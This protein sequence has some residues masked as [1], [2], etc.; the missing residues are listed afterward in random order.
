MHA[1][2]SVIALLGV[3]LTSFGVS[4]G[5]PMAA[6]IV[7]LLMIWEGREATIPLVRLGIENPYGRIKP[8][9][10]NDRSRFMGRSGTSTRERALDLRFR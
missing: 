5:D 1:Y 9:R 4:V 8:P 10:R 2:L 7:L 6:L 3:G